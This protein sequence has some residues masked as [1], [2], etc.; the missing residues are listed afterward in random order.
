[1]NTEHPS[2][3]FHFIFGFTFCRVKVYKTEEA[4]IKK[5]FEIGDEH[6][7][8]EIDD[9]SEKGYQEIDTRVLLSIIA[10]IFPKLIEEYLPDKKSLLDKALSELGLS[11]E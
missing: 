9:G 4:F 7:V 8:I 3:Y 5:L 10:S 1:M 11:Q 6:G 2:T